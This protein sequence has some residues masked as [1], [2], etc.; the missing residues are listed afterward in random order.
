M[1]GIPVRP[2]LERIKDSG[3]KTFQATEHLTKTHNHRPE[4]VQLSVLGGGLKAPQRM[5]AYMSVPGLVPFGSVPQYLFL[6]KKKKKLP[7]K[8]EVK[9]I[10]LGLSAASTRK[11]FKAAQY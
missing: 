3:G 5:H 11:I 8:S 1:G 2:V 10:E 6:K 9:N 4:R 7:G